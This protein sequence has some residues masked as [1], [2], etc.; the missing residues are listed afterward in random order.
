MVPSQWRTQGRL[1]VLCKVR[2]CFCQIC[3]TFSYLG[4]TTC[5]LIGNLWGVEK[6]HGSM[7]TFVHCLHS[8][9]NQGNYLQMGTSSTWENSHD[10]ISCFLCMDKK[11]HKKPI[12]LELSCFNYSSWQITKGLYWVAREN[13]GTT[14]CLLGYGSQN[15]LGISC[16]HRPN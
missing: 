3:T 9:F 5:F 16:E 11:F 6:T 7:T 10:Y 15:P 4:C 2:H 14:M 1:Q 8:T 12:Q 13:Y